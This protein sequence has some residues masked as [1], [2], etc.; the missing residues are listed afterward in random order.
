MLRTTV[1]LACLLIA[2]P[3]SAAAPALSSKTLARMAQ[4]ADRSEIVELSAHFDNALDAED[5]AKFVGTFTPDGELIGF[6]GTSEGPQG[7]RKA[8]E[9]MVSTFSKDKRHVV[10]N[11]EVTIQGDHASM[12]C[13]LTV[14]DRKS[15]A[16]TGTATFTDELVKHNGE[17]KFVRRT[18]RADPN[19]DPIIKS[20]SAE[21]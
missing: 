9:F 17:W 4:A 1:L 11:H 13:Y 12:F 8:F 7:L 2:V 14:F 15:L 18:L 16:V 3:A 6:W 5:P 21:H 19:V 20:L 10:T